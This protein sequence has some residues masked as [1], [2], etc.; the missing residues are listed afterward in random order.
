MAQI[1]REEISPLRQEVR[2]LAETIKGFFVGIVVEIQRELR[3]YLI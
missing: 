3:E 1:I 2:S